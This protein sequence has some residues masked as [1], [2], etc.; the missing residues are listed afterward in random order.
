MYQQCP[1]NYFCLNRAPDYPI[2]RLTILVM[3]MKASQMILPLLIIMSSR[4]M[5]M[6]S[7]DDATTVVGPVVEKTMGAEFAAAMLHDRPALTWCLV[8]DVCLLMLSRGHGLAYGLF[9]VR[10]RT[11]Y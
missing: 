6:I 11:R 1:Y 5:Y 8:F 4:L 3:M 7:C 10:R 2:R 9:L